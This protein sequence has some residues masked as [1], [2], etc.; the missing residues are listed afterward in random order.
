[1]K[2]EG[3]LLK[4]VQIG[5]SKGRRFYLPHHI[6]KKLHSAKRRSKGVRLALSED[7]RDMN[8]GSIASFFRSK[9]LPVYQSKIA[10]VVRQSLKDVANAAAGALG[11]SVGGPT[12]AMLAAQASPYINQGI[13]YVGNTTGGFGLRGRRRA[14]ATHRTAH[15]V[16]HSYMAPVLGNLP[17]FSK[18]D[19]EFS[20]ISAREIAPPRTVGRKRRVVGG[21]FLP[22]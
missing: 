1:M 9:V 13:D 19:F 11:E 22:A 12:G 2:G 18:P 5:H 8:G 4:P 14:P 21:S 17:D 20:G 3:I 15:G 10:P 6:V 7:D 16:S